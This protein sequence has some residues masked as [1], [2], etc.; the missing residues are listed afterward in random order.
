[1]CSIICSIYNFVP[2]Y[3]T[4]HN[5]EQIVLMQPRQALLD[6]SLGHL[7]ALP[8]IKA[9]LSILRDDQ[10]VN[11]GNQIT[12]QSPLQVS[13]YICVVQTR[14]TSKTLGMTIHQLKKLQNTKTFKPLISTSHISES[15]I[16]QLLEHDLEFVD[17]AGNIYLNSPA[18]YVLIRGKRPLKEKEASQSAFSSAGLKLIYAL[19]KSP[20]LLG[21]TVRHMAEVAE[22]SIGS[23]SRVMNDLHQQGYLQQQRYGSFRIKDYAELLKRWEMGYAERLRSKLLIGNYT[24]I[25]NRPFSEV[26]DLILQNAHPDHFLIGGELGAA[27]ATS[28]LRPQGATLHVENELLAIAIT[29]KLRLKPSPTGE[30]VLLRQFGTQNA[31][32]DQKVQHLVDPLL[33]HP[34]LLLTGNDRLRE[35]AERLYSQTIESRADA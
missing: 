23:V 32:I 3:V 22:V 33:I 25:N 13:H 4:I 2:E 30:I 34:E 15:A 18:A 16:D 31:W 1:M 12:I 20:S 10:L 29:V 7:N 6:Q 35:T 24:P 26:V 9:T 27:I 17:A 14:V 28:Y 19:L 11:S 8:H 5:I 21:T